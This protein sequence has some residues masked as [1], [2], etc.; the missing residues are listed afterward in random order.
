MENEIRQR[1]G[2]LW[3]GL[4]SEIGKENV[5]IIQEAMKKLFREDPL[6]ILVV[7]GSGSGK[8][9]TIRALLR[10]NNPQEEK[11]MPEIGEGA[12]PMTMDIEEFKINDNLI[13]YDSPG[14]GDGQKDEQHKR[15]IQ[16]L[17]QEKNDKGNALIDLALVLIDITSRDLGGTLSTIKAVGEVM[18]PDDRQKRILIAL[19]KCDKS[20]DPDARMN[21]DKEPPEPNDELQEEIEKRKNEF[22]KRIKQET[23]ID[24]EVVCYSAGFYNEKKN[25]DYPSYNID[26][27]FTYIRKDLPARKVV[28]LN[29]NANERVYKGKSGA[30]N[31]SSFWDSLVETIKN[32][33]ADVAEM[34]G[35]VVLKKGVKFISSFFGKFFKWIV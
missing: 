34:L 24:T 4:G 19:N 7:G 6:R 5:A 25:K 22:K 15:K 30:Q 17:L 8:S 9:S 2:A 16:N 1:I 23:G 27:L 14:L 28:I 3:S 31:E 21:Y 18:S 11:N 33:A 10:A 12:K 13:I 35:E 29:Q 26:E 32:V 20:N